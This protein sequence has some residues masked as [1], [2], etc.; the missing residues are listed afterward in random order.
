MYKQI[1]VVRKDLKMSKGKMAAQ[2]AHAAIE[3]FRSSTPSKR[4]RWLRGG[5]KKVVVYARNLE[6]FKSI[7]SKCKKMKINHAVIYDAGL[8]EVPPHTPTCIGIGPDEEERINKIT[9]NLPLVK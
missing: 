3:T 1:I 7:L 4:L 6:E 2:V 9:G 5:Q 8:T